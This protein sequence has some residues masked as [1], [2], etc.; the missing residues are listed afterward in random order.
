M[1]QRQVAHHPSNVPAHEGK[2][3]QPLSFWIPQVT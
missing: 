1:R 3:L 2:R